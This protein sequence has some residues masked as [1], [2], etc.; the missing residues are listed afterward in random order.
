M[1]AFL[2]PTPTE[3][4]V[5]DLAFVEDVTVPDGTVFAQGEE[6]EKVWLVRNEGTCNWDSGYRLR[7]IAGP[8]MGA[9]SEQ[10]LFPARSGGEAEIRITF[11]APGAA[12]TYKSSWQAFNPRDEA[13]GEPIFI[14]IVVE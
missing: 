10:A 2:T 12:G 1:L 11:T 7:L 5:D 6:I 14:E 3:A 13:F 9:D 4:C 8:P